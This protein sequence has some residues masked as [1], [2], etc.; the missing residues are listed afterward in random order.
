MKL[1]INKKKTI[2]ALILL[3]SLISCAKLPSLTFTG[4]N[5]PVEIKTIRINNFYNDANA[6]PVNLGV[7]FAEETRDFYQKNTPLV[8]VTNNGDLEIYGKIISYK[9]APIAA[10]ANDL[11]TAE[12]QRLSVT[13]SIDFINNFDEIKSFEQD[14][15]FFDD[16]DAKQNLAEVEDQLLKTIFNQIITDIFN[17]TV[18]DW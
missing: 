3:C 13:V 1:M 7:R 10:R 5:L 14:F 15:S 16:F 6:G 2:V 4:I 17:K 8:Q 11:Q 18:A 9:V 12:R